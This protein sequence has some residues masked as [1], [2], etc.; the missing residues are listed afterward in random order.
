LEGLHAVRLSEASEG[1][2]EHLF[3]MGA[4]AGEGHVQFCRLTKYYGV[5]EST[6]QYV[7]FLHFMQVL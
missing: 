4:F 3:N 5:R 7:N 1:V 2:C 6:V